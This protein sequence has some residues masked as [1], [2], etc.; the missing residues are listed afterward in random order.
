[1]LR[2]RLGERSVKGHKRQVR[3]VLLLVRHAHACMR[4]PRRPFASPQVRC[5][6][7]LVRHGQSVF[8]SG[9]LLAGWSDVE[10]SARGRE[11]ARLCGRLVRASPLTRLTTVYTSVLTRS[12][13][14]AW[15]ML[16]ELEQQWVP[17][18]STWRLNE[19]QYGALTGATAAQ[20]VDQFGRS[21]ARRWLHGYVPLMGLGWPLTASLVASAYL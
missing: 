21:C 16:D 17:V 8:N 4:S 2:E 13:K 5:V 3:C 18:R 6:L 14:T 11:E 10:L 15:L 20:I 9:G 19:R 12:I 7:L 1:M